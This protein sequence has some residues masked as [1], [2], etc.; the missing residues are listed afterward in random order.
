MQRVEDFLHDYF[1][2]RTEM[3]RAFGRA[4][5]PVAARFLSPKY[6]AFRPELTAQKSEAESILSVSPRDHGAEVITTGCLGGSHRMRY[7]LCA[8][9]DSWQITGIEFEC[10]LCHGTGKRKDGQSDCR[11]CKAKGWNLIGQTRAN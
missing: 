3:H 6:D 9:A 8:A 5:E 4:Y 11:L 7:R 10:S 1:R 2:A